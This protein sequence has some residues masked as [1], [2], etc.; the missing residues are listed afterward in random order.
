M[1]NSF[2]RR[3]FDY[4]G[5]FAPGGIFDYMADERWGDNSLPPPILLN[6]SRTTKLDGT[7]KYTPEQALEYVKRAATRPPHVKNRLE[8]L[9]HKT[10][11]DRMKRFQKE[12]I[13][14]LSIKDL[15]KHMQSTLINVLNDL[16]DFL[17]PNKNRKDGVIKNRNFSTFIGIFTQNDRLIYLG[18]IIILISVLLLL[19]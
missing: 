5:L 11:L 3:D 13:I 4:K 15:A 7:A 14:N 6:D 16:T 8:T 9:M 17:I 1:T 12:K 2:V 19:L 10:N 18:F